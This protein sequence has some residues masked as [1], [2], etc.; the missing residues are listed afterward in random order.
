MKLSS[1]IERK[2]KYKIGY[3][4][5]LVIVFMALFYMGELTPH[6]EQ[7][8][9]ARVIMEYSNLKDISYN[10]IQNMMISN[11]NNKIIQYEDDIYYVDLGNATIHI[12]NDTTKEN[13]N[14]WAKLEVALEKIGRIMCK[15]VYIESKYMENSIP[16]AVVEMLIDRLEPLCTFKIDMPISFLQKTEKELKRTIPY[17]PSC[18]NWKETT[19]MFLHISRCSFVLVSKT[20]VRFVSRALSSLIIENCRINILDLKRINIINARLISLKDL[21][22]TIRIIFPQ[23]HKTEGNMCMIDLRNLLPNVNLD[24]LY[25]FIPRNIENI[26]LYLDIS[27]VKACIKEF[28]TGMDRNL[29]QMV[30][31]DCL[32]LDRMPFS[33][34][35]IKHL[36]GSPWISID[37]LIVH[38]DICKTYKKT[39]CITKVFSLETITKMGVCFKQEPHIDVKV[40]KEKN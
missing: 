34:K 37:H 17:A 5:K 39:K 15:D 40:A 24:G 14:D 10:N 31:V 8:N 27:T 38:P 9:I 13:P 19:P 26:I 21:P 7:E 22:K 4:W 35:K 23:R 16:I 32:E 18:D 36:F 30:K 3:V 29:A 2:K 25:N 33:Y 6:S 28:K 20:L 1:N 11:H 12:T